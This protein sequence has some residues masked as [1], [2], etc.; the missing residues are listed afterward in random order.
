[1]KKL[2]ILLVLFSGGMLKAQTDTVQLLALEKEMMV[3]SKTILTDS[4]EENRLVAHES[5]KKTMEKAL[6]IE[7]SFAY[8]FD[9]LSSI[10]FQYPDDRGFRI[11]TWQLYVDINDYRYGGFIQNNQAKAGIFALN[12]Q[13]ASVEELEYDVLDAETWFGAVYYNIKSFKQKEGKRY[14]LFGFNGHQLFHKRKV[15]EVLHFED[16]VPVFGAPVFLSD[17]P[18]RPDLTKNRLVMTYSAETTIRLN[19]DEQLGIIIFD[20]LLTASGS[21]RGQGP[22]FLPDGSYRGYKLKKGNWEYVEKVFDH[23][24]ETAPRP[25]PI[26]NE[27]RKGRNIFG[28][29]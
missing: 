26:L 25:Q 17:Q 8:P 11:I 10:S 13:S 5:L 7:G 9:S 29:K 19:F 21:I 15:A 16:N 28:N 1:M 27:G 20:N 24:Y 18:N 14:V 22:V 3:L 6:N 4:I 2:L 12:D 23:T